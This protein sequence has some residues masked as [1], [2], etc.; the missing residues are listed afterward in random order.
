M[1]LES[2]WSTFIGSDTVK[3]VLLAS[4]QSKDDLAAVDPGGTDYL[5]VA[6]GLPDEDGF[7]WVGAV[8]HAARDAEPKMVCVYRGASLRVVADLLLRIDE[9]ICRVAGVADLPEIQAAMAGG[10]N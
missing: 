3:R 5:L 4:V 10:L 9:D 7:R 6:E 2:P 8:G 1:K